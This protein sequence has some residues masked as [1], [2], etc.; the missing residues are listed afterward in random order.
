[1]TVS[2]MGSSM[3]QAAPIPI[4]FSANGL[5][6]AVKDDPSPLPPTWETCMKLLNPGFIPVQH[7]P[8]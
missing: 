1:M 4:Q 6:R 5:A 8:L 7:W 3:C 2:D